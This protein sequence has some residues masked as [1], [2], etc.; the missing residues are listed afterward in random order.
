MTPKEF[1][2]DGSADPAYLRE[3]I[4]DLKG[5]DARDLEMVSRLVKRLRTPLPDKVPV[6]L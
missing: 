4:E 5:L 1:F 2:D 6:R 3:L